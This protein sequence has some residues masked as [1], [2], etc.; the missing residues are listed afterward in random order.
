M[1]FKSSFWDEIGRHLFKAT[2]SENE[3]LLEVKRSISGQL[4]M[5]WA[6]TCWTFVLRSSL[7]TNNKETRWSVRTQEV[8]VC[9][10]SVKILVQE[11]LIYGSTIRGNGRF[12]CSVARKI[13]R[14]TA[15]FK[16]LQIIWRHAAASKR[17]K[18]QPFDRLGTAEAVLRSATG[19]WL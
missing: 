13:W 18:F 19:P 16:T 6:W 11:S 4:S 1:C 10:N 12:G 5:T 9:L 2:P 14:A 3:E 15:S 8:C 17:R 7:L